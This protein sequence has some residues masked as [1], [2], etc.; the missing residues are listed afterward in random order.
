MDAAAAHQGI[1][2]IYQEAVHQQNPLSNFFEQIMVTHSDFLATEYL[3]PPP[4]LTAWLPETDWFGQVDLFGADFVPAIDETFNTPTLDA[5]RVGAETTPGG[6]TINDAGATNSGDAVRRRHAVFKQSPWF[7]VPE[8]NQNAFSEQEGITLDERQVDLALSPHQPHA[9]NII[10]P[11]YLSQQSRDQVL[12]LVL[13]TAPSQVSISSFPSVDCLDKLV[14]VGIA[15]RTEG[16]AWIHPYTFDADTVRPEFLTALVVAGCICFGIPSVNKTGLVLQEI[17]RVSLRELAERDNSAMRELQYLQASMLWLD[18]GAFCGFRRKMEL[19]ES[20]LQVLVTS[21]RRAGRFDDVRY[22]TIMPAPDDDVEVLDKKWRQWVEQEAYKRLVYHLFEHD[23]YMTM[24]NQR[25]P[26]LS[27]AELTLPLP[28]SETL[29]LAPSAA[30]WKARILS[31]SSPNFRPSMRSILQE[32]GSISCLHG[33]FDPRIARS[34]YIHGLASQVW[35]HR[36]QAVL[37]H[38]LSDPAAQLWSRSRRQ[39]LQDCLRNTEIVLDSSSALTCMFQQFLQMYLHADLDIITRFAGRCGEEAA[40]RAYI[41]LQPWS[42]SREA[43]TAVAHA[44]Q[45]LQAARAII[46][47]QNRGQ[48]SFIIYHSIMVLWT[49]S[50]LISDHARKTGFNTPIQPSS[51]VPPE[52]TVLV[53]LDDA[54]PSNQAAVDAFIIMNTGTPCLRILP[55]RTRQTQGAAE[56]EAAKS[57]VC[58]L[59]YPWQVMEAGVALLD[60]THPDV[61]REIG[62]P[63][64]RALCGLMEELGGLPAS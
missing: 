6:T 5:G 61:D 62:P 49:Y 34:A 53:F 9:S 17:V 59:K 55:S 20:S 40:H 21:L 8:R 51:T 22:S 43:R 14:K 54:R 50:M 18:I 45:V 60:G 64:I 36:Q 27:Y 39:T 35:E 12:Q 19:A 10:I 44:G 3:C 26:L 11:G 7:W 29:W 47:Y 23:I 42:K 1:S 52:Q 2:N 63:L 30:V 58:N 48:D 57:N 25:Q 16:D 37:L 4:D 28:A 31:R 56:A 38:E 46:P 24:V 13:K 15:K 41:A 33:S 32:A